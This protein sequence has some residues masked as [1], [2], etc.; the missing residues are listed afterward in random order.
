M[1]YFI[2]K[3]CDIGLLWSKITI[4]IIEITLKLIL[5]TKYGWNNPNWGWLGLKSP[6]LNFFAISVSS[7]FITYTNIQL[8]V[9][10]SIFHHNLIFFKQCHLLESITIEKS[11]NTYSFYGS[12]ILNRQLSY[13]PNRLEFRVLMRW[14]GLFFY[15]RQNSNKIS[16]CFFYLHFLLPSN[17][18]FYCQI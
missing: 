11:K 8:H 2:S 6:K 18:F 15:L 9:T 12:T 1:D 5:H 4:F 17:M 16:A 14:S 10:G 3:I 13:M 7:K